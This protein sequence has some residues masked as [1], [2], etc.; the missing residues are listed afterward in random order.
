[1]YE[2]H[3]RPGLF[4]TTLF[5]SFIAQAI[6]IWSVL[7]MARALGIQSESVYF[8][9]FIPLI[10][11]VTMLPISLNGL[12]LR[13]GAFAF[14]F[15]QV[16]MISTE[17]VALSLLVYSCRLLAGLLG[18]VVFMQ[19]SIEDAFKKWFKRNQNIS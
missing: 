17:A 11:L 15:G 12:G 19:S 3:D 7:L 5:I 16:G 14:F 8:F 4:I 13:E 10:W 18:G 2:L 1:L 9:V 6:E